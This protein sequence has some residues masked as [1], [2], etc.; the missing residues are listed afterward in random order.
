MGALKLSV[1]IATYNRRATL[2]RT[3][4]SLFDQD[5]APDLYEIIVIVDGSSDGTTEYLRTLNP[6]CGFKIIEQP[7]RGQFN[8]LNAGLRAASG[9]IILLIDDD[10]ICERSV[11]SAHVA[12]HDAPKPRFVFGPIL[13]APESPDTLATDWTREN[14]DQW[15]ARLRPGM[16]LRWQ[17]DATFDANC[18]APRPVML[19]AGGFDERFT[20]TMANLEFGVRL[21]KMGV[22]FRYEP[23][24]VTSQVFVKPSDDLVL[25]DAYWTG[26]NEIAICRKHPECRAIYS[27]GRIAEGP[28]PKRLYREVVARLPFSIEPLMR[29]PFRL[30]ERMRANRSVRGVGLRL[31][32]ARQGVVMIRAA[33]EEAGSWDALRR[34]FATTLPVLMYHH[35]GP[36]RPGTYPELTIS[37][38]LFERHLRWLW[39]HRYTPIRSSDWIAWVREAKP[40]PA[41][42]VLITIDD[43][44]A[45][46]AEFALPIL[47]RHGFTAV[48][49]VV[50]SQI[51]GTNAWDE[52]QGSGTH[53]LMS[54]DQIRDWTRAGIE[55]GVHTRTHPDLRSLAPDR[56]EAEIAGSADDL[57]ELT[58]ERPASFAYP[59]GYYND[60]ALQCAGHHFALAMTCD[61]G[62]NTLATRPESLRRV[63]IYPTDSMAEFAMRVRLG[64]SP[65]QHLR[66]RLHPRARLRAVLRPL[67]GR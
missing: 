43:G 17:H 55:F 13:V 54:A 47:K 39:R 34:E 58:G 52:A 45:D 21:W 6:D 50:T 1:L 38:A 31:L 19:A 51:G 2:A 62:L 27:L 16:Q 37:P 28:L 9:D 18:S 60:A 14:T 5:L 35:V 56:L 61:E 66:A 59:Y 10:I 20:R 7:N 12:A 23:A 65:I 32:T 4:R 29:P 24:A 67:L 33:V 36:P 63:M 3:L 46:V 11:L 53:R 57:A 41:K 40:L 30:A 26:R 44:Y 49:Y 64:W 15:L 42:P 25:K 48:V 8:A 22:R